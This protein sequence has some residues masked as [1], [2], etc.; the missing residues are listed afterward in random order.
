MEFTLSTTNPLKA[1]FTN[2]A[3]GREYY[4]VETQHRLLCFPKES[5]IISSRKP[6]VTIE[7]ARIRWHIIAPTIIDYR[8]KEMR[9]HDLIK[10]KGCCRL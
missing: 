5:T 9:R 10:K 1:V 8:G 7:L 3:D 6:E 4:R 2:A